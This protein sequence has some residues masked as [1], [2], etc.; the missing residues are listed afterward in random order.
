MEPAAFHRLHGDY[1]M[2]ELIVITDPG[3][4][5]DDENM[6]VLAATLTR[7]GKIELLAVVANLAPAVRRAQLAAGTLKLV[8]LDQVPVGIGTGCGAGEQGHEQE[9]AQVPYMVPADHLLNG[10]FL[11]V[12]ALYACADKSVTLLLVSGLTDA[13]NLLREQETLVTQKVERVVIM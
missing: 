10:S 6:L 11:L 12:S 13:A 3:K 5:L 1:W 7:L 9:F 2:K 8:G 4:Y